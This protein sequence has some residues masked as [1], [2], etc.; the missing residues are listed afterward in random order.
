MYLE[1]KRY[2]FGEPRKY[3][4]EHM[5]HCFETIR[6]QLLCDA[7]DTIRAAPPGTAGSG[8]NQTRMCRD[9]DAYDSWLKNHTSCYKHI[10]DRLPGSHDI[11]EFKF[12][13][14]ESG[15]V[16][17]NDTYNGIDFFPIEENE[18]DQKQ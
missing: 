9:W 4:W 2:E 1:F 5:S 11:E 17:R 16:V 15:Y 10:D 12:C 13:P 18:D 3:P 6:Q 8:H 14:P 7:D